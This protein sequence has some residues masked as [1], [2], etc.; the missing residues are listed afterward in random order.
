ME[1]QGKCILGDSQDG[2]LIVL[3]GAIYQIYLFKKT[4]LGRY[5]L[6]GECAANVIACFN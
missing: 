4:Y 5:F 2:V 1:I 6:E 3:R